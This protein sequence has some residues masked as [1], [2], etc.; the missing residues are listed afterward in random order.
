MK[1]ISKKSL[2]IE[3]ERLEGF[4]NPKLF[5]E[6]YLTPPNL[7]AEIAVNA[8][9][10][11]DIDLVL[12][13]GC[14]TG[15]LTIA[16]ELL[17]FRSVGVDIDLDALKIAKANSKRIGVNPDFILCDVKFFESKNTFT[18]VM[19]PPFGIQKKH[20][21]RIFL[22]KALELGDVIYSIH[23]AGSEKFVKGIC[24]R[25]GFRITHVWRYLI[26]LKKT[27]D[28][29]EKEFK[30]IAVEVFRVEKMR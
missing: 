6:Q 21:D 24:E 23:S 8:S 3:L 14:G 25:S 13:L 12:D 26:P 17:G 10:L 18:V 9:L 20:A 1:K 11:D 30:R 28:F 29:H 27:Y 19:N 15:M 7:A 22:K 2:A 16:F 5:L 4:K